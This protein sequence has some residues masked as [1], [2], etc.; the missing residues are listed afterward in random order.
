VLSLILFQNYCV[1]IT[2]GSDNSHEYGYATAAH[3]SVSKKVGYRIDGPGTITKHNKS[4]D[5]LKHKKYRTP[6]FQNCN[7][8]NNK[9]LFPVSFVH[10]YINIIL[11]K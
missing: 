6:S 2:L 7:L 8:T 11:Q 9:M 10:N 5:C 3:E 1:I 4:G